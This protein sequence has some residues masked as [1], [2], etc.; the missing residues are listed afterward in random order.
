[1]SIEELRPKV[2]DLAQ[3]TRLNGLGIDEA[4]RQAQAFGQSVQGRQTG[5]EIV[6]VVTLL[7]RERLAFDTAVQTFRGIL[8]VTGGKT[9]FERVV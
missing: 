6:D 9:E 4:L 1:M 7:A 8:V 3:S 2:R 5:D